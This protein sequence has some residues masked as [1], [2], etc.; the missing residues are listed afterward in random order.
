MDISGSYSSR[1]TNSSKSNAA[2]T[3]I[4][5]VTIWQLSRIVS[6]Q[7]LIILYHGYLWQRLGTVWRQQDETADCLG[8]VLGA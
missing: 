5:N 8:V 7:S 3:N 6:K 4:Y 2:N 1:N